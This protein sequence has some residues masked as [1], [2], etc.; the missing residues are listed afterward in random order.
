MLP[1]PVFEHSINIVKIL[2]LYTFSARLLISLIFFSQQVLAKN[3]RF[4]QIW[5][6]R[7]GHKDELHHKELR[8]MCHF[9]DVVCVDVE[10]KSNEVQR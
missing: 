8:E 6:S 10:E 2:A 5:R 3:A 7:K 1:K 4:E 9:Y